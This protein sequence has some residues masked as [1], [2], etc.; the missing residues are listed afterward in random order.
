MSEHH[1]FEER[2]RVSSQTGNWDAQTLEHMETCP[3]C[4]EQAEVSRFMSALGDARISANPPDPQVVKLKAQIVNREKLD[5]HTAHRISNVQRIIWGA[6]ALAILLQA[7]V[8]HLPFLQK[9]FSTVG[10]SP[11]DWL[12]CAATGSAVLWLRELSK[13]AYRRRA[14]R[15]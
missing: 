10:L 11:R 6:I 8:V 15:E 2:I 12:L 9:A 14:A 3:A 7:A 1:H 13:L 4:S 5:E